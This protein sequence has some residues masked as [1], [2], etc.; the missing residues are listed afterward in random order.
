M[1]SVNIDP[2]TRSEK[3]ETP[4]VMMGAPGSPYTRKMRSL[5]RYRHIPYRMV[6][7]NSPEAAALP[8]PKVPLLPTFY[9]PD[10]QGQIVATTDSTP[11]IRRFERAFPGR[12]VIPSDPVIAFLDEILEDYADE[13]LTKCMFHY[14]WYHPADIDKAARV[15]PNWSQ[16]QSTDEVIAPI[17]KMIGERQISRLHVVGSNDTTAPV[18]E[19]SYRRFI[20]ALDKHL[21]TNRFLL[22]E[23]PASADF[24][25]HGQLTCLA[26]FD[27]TPSAITLEE[28]PRVYAWVEITEDLS[29]L[30]D[31]TEAAW[32]SRKAV[33]DTLRALLSEVGRVHAPF[34]LANAE[35]LNRGDEQVE[36]V[37]DGKPWV[38]KPFPYQGKC[39]R[40]LRESYQGLDESDRQATDAI[41]AGTGCELLFG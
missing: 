26:L 28:S 4:L 19:E 37:I 20:R 40:W 27:P 2:M 15:L 14:R 9:L 6:L 38:Q 21:Q 12:S 39:L 34:L 36:S 3:L 30:S 10:A 23:Q 5:M 33:P 16:G 8:Q 24:A 1:D 25:T 31:P 41:L 22:G 18:I 32:I 17:Q 13:W 35:A 29:G 7:Q 11:L